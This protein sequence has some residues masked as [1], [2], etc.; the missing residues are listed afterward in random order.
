[1]LKMTA[2]FLN[3]TLINVIIIIFS[4]STSNLLV[5]WVAT[6]HLSTRILS[7]DHAN[8]LLT[9]NK[10]KK[11][12]VA[13]SVE[14]LFTVYDNSLLHAISYPVSF[15]F[16]KTSLIFGFHGYSYYIDDIS[17]LSF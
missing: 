13:K 1:M 14:S 3:L 8:A 9:Y 6:L 16:E 17:L 10:M 11:Y 15:L 7:R 2:P 5:I 12:P 4:F